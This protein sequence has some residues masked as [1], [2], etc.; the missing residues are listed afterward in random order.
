MNKPCPTEDIWTDY[1]RHTLD[2]QQ[3]H[4]LKHHLHTCDTCRNIINSLEQD[5]IL[6]QKLRRAAGTEE[7]STLR[8][9]IQ[10]SAENDYEIIEQ[11]GSGSGGIIFK[12]RDIRLNRLVALK[13]PVN[14]SQKERLLKTFKEART[15][16]RIN[17]THIARIYQLCDTGPVPFMV[18][19]YIEGSTILKAAEN[20]S[21][22]RKL[23]LFEQVLQAVQELHKHGIVHRD[24]K[25]DNIMVTNLGN[26][27]V[28]DLGIA[29]EYNN[30][31]SNTVSAAGTPAYMAPEQITNSPVNPAMDVFSLGI[32]LFELLTGQRPFKGETVQKVIQAIQETPPQL[33]R[34]LNINI[35]GPLQAVCLKA[36]EKQPA[37]RYTNIREFLLD[38][39]QFKQGEPVTANPTLLNNIL[40]HGVQRHLQELSQWQQDHL[41]SMR[42]YDYLAGKYESLDQREEIWALDSRRISFSQVVL[43]LGAWS[44]VISVLLMLCFNWQQLE[45]WQRILFPGSIFALLSCTGL[46]LWHRQTKRVSLVLLIAAALTCALVTATTLVTMQWLTPEAFQ[47]TAL[48]N[49]NT[50]LKT[51]KPETQLL[52]DFLS[53][54]QLLITG[55]CWF[56]MSTAIWLK[57][58]TSA[59]SLI[60]T[61]S[62]LGMATGVFSLLGLRS[63]LDNNEFDTAAALYLVPVLI[64]FITAL[65][66]DLHFQAA[67]LAASIY[68]ISIIC[69]LLCMTLIAWYGPTTN[70]LGISKWVTSKTDEIAYSLMINGGI[71]FT[72]GLI[73]DCSTRSRWLRRMGQLFFWLTP[74][75]ILA[76]IVY[77]TTEQKWSWHIL[78]QGW[79]IAELVL[80][81]GALFF[82]FVSVPKQMKSFFFSGLFYTAAAVIW[83]THQHF[84]KT[85]A[86][87]MSLA[88]IG[89]ILTVIA[90]YNPALF[91]KNKNPAS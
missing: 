76:P 41:I 33:P 25:P 75:H 64:L 65:I 67:P 56:L 73:A 24:L 20:L 9:R 22:K 85:F 53:N 48:S 74:T 7:L 61:L 19:E 35:P 49:A 70:W 46:Y 11:T 52:G 27:K 3:M 89:I 82:V 50:A 37:Q 18:M 40:E 42:E 59:F 2:Q 90:W 13:C 16:A 66:L 81:A 62:V 14:Y 29:Q 28:L 55:I 34:S 51:E 72:L 84:Q 58:K 60:W 80:P 79:T 77:F 86:W 78:P 12:A 23:D 38:I 39:Q 57:T 54:Y 10:A 63:Y 15:L 36:L 31:S 32:I 87:P 6:A 5:E 83:L 1:I 30:I 68:C 69:F 47:Q 91:E 43:H 4:K 17:H 45:K 26:V 21:L 8:K 71:Y 88:G 44:C